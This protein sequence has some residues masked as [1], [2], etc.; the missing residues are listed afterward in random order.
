L[1]PDID[2]KG[3]ALALAIDQS[4][5][6]LRQQSLAT[7]TDVAAT[8]TDIGATQADIAAHRIDENLNKIT[9]WLSTTD[10]S[11]NH[12]A[13]CRKRQPTTG[14]W[15]IV[16]A[17]FEEWKRARN[18]LLWLY[19]IRLSPSLLFLPVY[20]KCLSVWCTNTRLVVLELFGYVD[21]SLAQRGT[22]L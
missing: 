22:S 8:R 1:T 10:P 18:S 20:Q 2:P 6:E 3:R 11:S 4:V 9:E 19:G 17:D 13:A 16:R 12:H 14:E 21:S 5:A 15:F 7:R